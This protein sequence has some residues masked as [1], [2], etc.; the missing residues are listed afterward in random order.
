MA[1]ENFKSVLQ[2]IL[3]PELSGIKT[4]LVE[5][6]KHMVRIDS[7]LD[8]VVTRIDRIEADLREFYRVMGL[9][10]ARLDNLEKKS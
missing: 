9:H 5:I 6:D 10:E 8:Y 1:V 2:A 3:V 7:R 4:S